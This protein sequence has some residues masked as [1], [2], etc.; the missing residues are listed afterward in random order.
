MTNAAKIAVSLLLAAVAAG[1]AY[2]LWG[3]S[4]VAPQ[5]VAP[6]T[7]TQ[8]TQPK[9]T[10]P[11]PVVAPSVVPTP[12]RT[13]VEATNNAAQADA[14]QGVKGRVVLPDGNAAA[15]VTVMLVENV[16]MD[17]ASLFL[18]NK[19]TKAVVPLALSKTAADGSF[20]LGLRQPG[21][22][23]DLRIVSDDHP[24]KN[25]SQLRVRA[26][27]WYDAG[28]IRLEIGS[29]VQGRVVEEDTQLGVPNATVFLA[30]SHQ[31]HSVLA[32]P[33][34]ERGIAAL[35]DTSGFFRFTSAPAQGLVNLTV[36][37]VGYASSPVL[38]QPLKPQVA[39]EFTLQV[40]RGEPIAGIVVDPDGRP[41]GGANVSATGLSTK[42]PQNATAVTAADG[43][44][45]FPSLRIGPYQLSTTMD[46]FLEAREPMVM[47]GDTA[48][49]L[50]LGSRAFLKLRV[51]AANGSPVKAYRISLTRYF[52]NNPAGVGKVLDFPDRNVNP[53]DYPAEYR[54]EWALVRGLP[55][56]DFRMQVEDRAHAKTLS[57]PFSV[58][59]GGP[60]PEVTVEL[61]LGGSIV[62]TVLDDRGQPVPDAVVTTDMNSGVAADI[63]FLDIFRSMMP[64][65]HSKAQTRTDAQGRFRVSKL[66]FADYM[67]RISHPNY[68]EG[69]AINI[70]LETPGQVADAGVIQLS[71]GAIVEGLTTIGG[72][73]A[74]QIQVQVSTPFT[75]QMNQKDP[76]G[77][78][79]L[80][81]FN[82]KA[83]S[84]GDGRYRLLK[85]VP[86]G[87]YKITAAR[88]GA[89][90]PFVGM[91]DMKDSEQQLV[92][93]PGQD[94][95][96]INLNLSKR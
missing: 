34:R 84:D 89:E 1:A 61:T 12:V 4:A 93:A 38:N 13:E 96:V 66:A 74:G 37:A 53:S 9:S 28:D 71:A 90:N 45:T 26:D 27:D 18:M 6:P 14:P 60:T 2:L 95:I 68:C 15:G 7:A 88:Q 46:G 92:V 8:P 31:A 73:P 44:F 82:S 50:V 75:D 29:I 79:L 30:S 65:K 40:V 70:K 87:T 10:G 58:V 42:T 35:T 85:R 41:V 33:G 36:E 43:T 64:E 21:K 57:P 91:I 69:T 86:P 76:N 23:C 22:A 63:G 78:P 16:A 59:E 24:E 54:G 52:P 80:T 81:M 11:A 3:Q 55:P 83:I 56:G 67:L 62:G 39:N 19:T 48:V 72:T 25:L 77:K 47:S 49:K 17:A 20:A 5:P 94:R 51:L 32:T